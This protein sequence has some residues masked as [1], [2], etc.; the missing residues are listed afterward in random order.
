MTTSQSKTSLIQLHL[1][2]G[3]FHRA[4][5]AMYMQK[6]HNIGETQWGIIAGNIRPDM[7][8]VVDILQAQNNEY[9]L[10]TISPSGEHQYQL[11]Q[12]IKQVIDWD[13]E[14][15]GITT[16]AANKNTKIISFT[17][18]EAGYY[19]DKNYKLDDS[20]AD[21]QSDL[22]G[23]EPL[24]IYGTLTR[25]LRAR[26][27]KHSSPV[28]LLNCDNLSSNGS[29]F[30]NALLEYIK[31]VGD[32]KLLE[33]VKTK[34][35]SPNSMVDRITP[36][37]TA[38]V[39]ERVLAATDRNDKAALMG[40]SFN[41]WVIE[42]NFIA[43]RPPWEK[44]KVELVDDVHPYE[45]AKIRLLNATHSC[46]AWAGTL[47]GYQYIH[48]GS[49]DPVVSK[50]AFDYITN[51]VIP[52]LSSTKHPSPVNLEDYRDI[53]IDR[54][55]NPHIQDT[56][57]RVAMD[58][59]SK[60]P[61]F[62]LPTIQD[63]LRAGRTIDSVAILPALFLAFLVRQ[64]KGEIKYEYQDQMMSAE[65]A[66]TIVLSDDIV[67]AFANDQ[68]LFGHNAGNSTLLEALREAYNRVNAFI[69]KQNQAA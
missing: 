49:Q 52:C 35:T 46:I 30:K 21:L 23:N 5:Q 62:I 31:K 50:L 11:I 18:T 41:Q 42:D 19:L 60:I 37:P 1:G 54:F 13:K 17:V 64:Q 29:R 8:S 58:A 27:E 26:M 9:T 2:L 4:H 3:S 43:G 16:V 57:Q 32:Q 66:E 67:Q 10:E 63:A 48:E 39:V 38:D 33:W 69:D 59:Y 14:M 47:S 36:R 61:S 24:T 15:N 40:E 22:A 20:F 34:T 44:V 6:L 68:I 12:S 51:D 45:E 53:V 55:S 28:T 7:Q 65:N 25:L 56:N